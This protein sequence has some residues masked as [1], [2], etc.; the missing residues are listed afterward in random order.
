MLRPSETAAAPN[1]K[2]L[3][4]PFRHHLPSFLR[5]LFQ[6]RDSRSALYIFF[7]YPSLRLDISR[8]TWTGNEYPLPTVVHRPVRVARRNSR[9]VWP[10]FQQTTQ[11]CDLLHRNYAVPPPKPPMPRKIELRN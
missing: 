2:E 8:E 6:D 9:S 10:S 3:V 7:F 4:Q 5:C 11:D 1:P